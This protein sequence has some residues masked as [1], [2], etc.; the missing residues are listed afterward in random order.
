MAGLRGQIACL[1][2]ASLRRAGSINEVNSVGTPGPELRIYG[3]VLLRNSPLPGPRAKAVILALAL[4]RG[5]SLS[6][7]VLIDEVWGLD[8]PAGATTALHTMVS[9]I[10]TSHWQGLITSADAGYALSVAPAEIDYWAVDSLLASARAALGQPE[11][12]LALLDT[13]AS[14]S[15]G[16]AAAGTAAS[17][18]LADFRHRAEQQRAAIAR[19][20]AQAL[21]AN[22]DHEA[23]AD[24]LGTLSDAAPL[25][26]TVQLEYLTA[27][28]A[29]GRSAAA[30]SAYDT[31]RRRLR[32]ELGTSPAPALT[33]LH[34]LLLQTPSDAGNPPA[35]SA[36]TLVE[37]APTRPAH[38]S[39]GLRAAPNELLG[40]AG[41]V[42]AIE[43]LMRTGRLTTILGIGGLG[44]TRV[45]QE[46]ANRSAAR[47]T[48][49]V[50]VV[51]LAG[52]RTPEDLWLSL[53]DAAGIQEA[54]AVRALQDKRPVV[55]PRNR[56]LAR[57]AEQTT[58]LVMDNCE[59]LI[60]PA[61]E[62]VADILAKCPGVSVLATSRSP[63]SIA[64]ERI[65]Q[66]SPL[67]TDGSSGTPVPAAVELF[68]ERALAARPGATLDGTVVRRLCRA[69][70]GLPLAIELAAA[71]VRLMSVE[72][73]E[74]RLTHR[75][76]LLVNTDRTA[77]DRH[78]T[79]TAVIGWSW[80]LLTGNERAV[81]R[82]LAHF[83]S[84]FSLAAALATVGR[85]PDSTG[86]LLADTDIE[87]GLEALINQSLV[88]AEDD[89]GTGLVRFRMLETVREYAALRL[90]QS[91]E[92]TQAERAMVGWAVAFAQHALAN[93]SGVHQLETIRHVTAE[94]EN[95]LHALRKALAATEQDPEG[96]AKDV[97]AI[98][99]ILANYWSQRG[100]HGEVF[101]FAAPILDATTAYR[102][103]PETADAAVFSLSVI[104]MTTMIFSLRQGAAARVRI[105][106]IVRSGIHLSP[107]TDAIARLLLA[108]GN[109]S[110]AMAL[111][112]RLRHD[113]HDDVA[114]LALLLSGLWAENNG[115]PHDA[116]D[117]AERSFALSEKLQ[118][119]WSSGSAAD[120]AAQ[121]YS[122]SGNPSQGL[123]W[124]GRAIERMALVGAEPDIRN[125]TLMVALN[126]AALGEAGPA[127]QALDQVNLMPHDGESQS[128]LPMLTT[129]AAAEIAFAGNQDEEGLRL[130]RTLG[131]P[132]VSRRSE[133]PV[134]LILAA[135]QL[136]AELLYNPDVATSTDAAGAAKRL[137]IAGIVSLRHSGLW[138]DQP[139]HGSA[140]LAVGAW[141]ATLA[142]PGSAR[143]AVGLE[144]MA[145]AEVMAGRQDEAVLLR[146]RHTPAA[147]RRH[148]QGAL[149]AAK[150]S[151]AGLA[152]D[153]AQAA[154]RL[155]KLYSSPVLRGV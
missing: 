148:G 139:V 104:C 147:S 128:E 84:G 131:R 85:I 6:S 73:I 103:D 27:L 143:A 65:H 133:G 63:L 78:R 100:M 119:T 10:R 9:R 28:H 56:T 113:R 90:G 132:T 60:D 8:A 136:C 138:V 62:A 22:G 49:S 66:L 144:L 46:L 88:L 150:R 118:D 51:E 15:S 116:I 37:P 67:A 42:A 1:A 129:A 35:V 82:R 72:D 33:R 77:P 146:R 30:L 39:F 92:N 135:A 11:R 106:R 105:G 101:V 5:R 125:A 26:E 111:M 24:M 40:R 69:L 140:A 54:R 102:P 55:D 121:L 18:V 126:H 112:A 91:G 74:R 80:E 152:T 45:A 155:L 83:P 87:G 93:S 79:L 2:E 7:A 108:A 36:P 127:Q 89:P 31:F 151:V 48:P 94:Q 3:G 117:F 53:A 153:Q 19:L 115:R 32:H 114:A 134:G 58:L 17:P 16:D 25:D 142:E 47:G 124:A 109:E 23:A 4:A 99:G 61:A 34:A 12:A 21:A 44:K 123:R 81:A 14:L 20:Q 107:L 145:L 97:F 110:R 70:D 50:L 41:D 120:L 154:E 86:Q 57:L 43:G 13:A 98:F 38:Q 137:R 76:E 52:I 149:D 71:R 130:Y 75:F 29:S 122:Q 64:G 141:H 68:L 59:H 96:S 95:L